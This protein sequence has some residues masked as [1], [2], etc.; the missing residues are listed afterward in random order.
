M[1]WHNYV[2]YFIHSSLTLLVLIT[3]QPP[4]S[5]PLKSCHVS[6]SFFI[7][8]NSLERVSENDSNCYRSILILLNIVTVSWVFLLLTSTG[9]IVHQ[10]LFI[11]IKSLMDIWFKFGYCLII[12]ILIGRSCDLLDIELEW[13]KWPAQAVE[14]VCHLVLDSSFFSA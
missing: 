6:M 1:W 14:W 11:T 7:F 4:H 3:P 2:I 12:A 5:L 10:F 13:P 8:N 9:I